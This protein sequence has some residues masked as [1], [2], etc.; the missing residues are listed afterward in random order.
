MSNLCEI[1]MISTKKNYIISRTKLLEIDACLL[2]IRSRTHIP[3]H[4]KNKSNN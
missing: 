3:K 4:R 2:Q 1:T